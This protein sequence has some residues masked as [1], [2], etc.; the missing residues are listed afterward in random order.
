M[1]FLAKVLRVV[2][3]GMIG[4]IMGWSQYDIDRGLAAMTCQAFSVEE[5]AKQKGVTI[6]HRCHRGQGR[7]IAD[8]NWKA[9]TMTAGEM[10]VSIEW[11]G[12]V[13]AATDE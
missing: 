4:L 5:I 1:P 8:G 12:H 3:R 6:R 2:S 7:V 9:I 10:T 11:T 13:V